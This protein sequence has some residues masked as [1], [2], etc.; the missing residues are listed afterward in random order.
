MT[1]N[2]QILKTLMLL[3][4]GLLFFRFGS[5]TPIPYINSAVFEELFKSEAGG[6]LQFLNLVGGGSLS[7]MSV[8]TLGIMPYISAGIM[9]YIFQLASPKFKELQGSEEGKIK[10][11]QFKRLLTLFIVFSQ[12]MAIARILEGQTINGEYVASLTGVNFYFTT[13]LALL[14]GTFIVVWLANTLTYIGVGSGVSL[15]I[16]FGICA[17]L[18]VTFTTMTDLLKSGSVSV[19]ELSA[20]AS[21]MLVA[22]WVVIKVENGIR[23]V[24]VLKPTREGVRQST[25][26]FKANPVGIMPPIFSAISLSMPIALLDL[27]SGFSPVWVSN[28]K[29]W[30]SVG[31]FPHLIGFLVLTY[32]FGFVLSGVM[33]NPKKQA[34]NL[35][36][37]GVVVKGYRPGYPTRDYLKRLFDALTLIACTYLVLICSIPEL[38]QMSIGVPVYMSGTSILIIV[39][40]SS[41]IRSGLRRLVNVSQSGVKKER[42]LVK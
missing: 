21:V 3:M 34:E 9:I 4:G 7:R 27:F 1:I 28:V 8:F 32:V 42:V 24:P 17:S 18:P 10:V 26:T 5:H 20:I 15:V 13:F 29:S 22:L 19:V 31:S 37:Q 41:D 6:V 36:N 14:S 23:L 12:S 38:V 2:N 25:I 39:S 30:L 35:S 11:E 40:V 16:L 33:L